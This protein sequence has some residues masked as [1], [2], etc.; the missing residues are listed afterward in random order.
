MDRLQ[1]AAIAI[2]LARLL[3]EHKS[4][5]GE[6]HLQKAMYVLQD[7]LEVPI[8]LD[9]V[10]Y[11]HGPYSFEFRDELTALRA[12]QLLA[13]EPQPAPYRPRLAPT[14]RSAKLEGLFPEIIERFDSR[15]RFVAKTFGGRGVAELER[16]STALFITR[17][18]PGDR[19]V[20]TRAAK[21]ND[22][23]PHVSLLDARKA[24]Q[25]VD[26]LIDEAATVFHD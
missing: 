26:S 22:L 24:V 15:M 13:L 18:D 10:I 8:A 23:K 3:R 6:T 5:C 1:R 12:D 9:F 16:L 2:R 19:A 4:W 11:K 25:E 7:L 14:E 17:H 20:E 21:L